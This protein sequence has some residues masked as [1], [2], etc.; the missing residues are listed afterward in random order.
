MPLVLSMRC[1]WVCY[2]WVCIHIAPEMHVL[3]SPVNTGVELYA[4]AYPNVIA[5]TLVCSIH[6]FIMIEMINYMLW[7]CV[8][9]WH[10]VLTVSIINVYRL[11]QP[12]T[13]SICFLAPPATTAAWV[14]IRYVASRLAPKPTRPDKHN[15]CI[16]L[17]LIYHT[18]CIPFPIKPSRKTQV[19]MRGVE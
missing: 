10:D 11:G 6:H 4:G 8:A 7:P 12:W 9:F 13:F 17:V 15:Q 5:L 2:M 18:T 16:H 1:L 14:F 3:S 19:W